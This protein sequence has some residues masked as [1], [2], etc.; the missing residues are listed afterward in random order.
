[1]RALAGKGAF[2]W[3]WL[4]DDLGLGIPVALKSLPLSKSPE[5]R[6]TA[7]AAL[8][9]EARLLAALNH[10][11]IV[12]VHALRPA[13]GEVYLI[14][15]YVPGGSLADRLERE[16]PLPWQRAARYIAD[17]GDALVHVHAEGIVHR[18]IKA[19][20]LLWDPVR[21][22]ALLTDFG[23]AGRL[24]RDTKAAGTPLY[25]APEAFAGEATPAGDVY[26]LAATLFQ[27]LTGEAPFPA[28]SLDE[29]L[30]QVAAGLP[31]PD[32]RCAGIPEP[33]ERVLRSALAALPADRPDLPA[34]VGALRGTL[35][36]LLADSLLPAVGQPRRPGPVELRLV[37]S[38]WEGG[39][40]YQP[41]ATTHAAPAPATRNL[42]KV[43]PRPGRVTLRTG[44]QVRVEVLADRAGHVTV[45]NVGP[46]GDLT[47]LYPGD[48]PATPLVAGRALD[49]LNVELTPP[50]GRER[51]VA[52]WSRVPLKLPL[53]QLLRLTQG[54]PG[55]VSRSYRA[56]RN[57]E[58]VRAA[59]QQLPPGDWHATVL[60]LDHVAA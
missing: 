29:L 59:V 42:T 43:P 57:L 26:A 51:L 21:D 14:L 30:R 55:P 47:L 22:E 33:L 56:T 39:D 37:V 18:D 52:V 8:R 6:A 20:N 11:N 40:T 1:V 50:A 17:A 60:E 35:N 12:R 2:S 24:T 41:M 19:G 27:L 3:V 23:L 48:V 7:L 16:G 46:S 32:P 54:D 15:Q 53:N 4:A 34:F 28:S 9:S 49:I 13:G 10:P 36:Q 58:R 38:R 25:M 44:D 31:E 45:F 5:A